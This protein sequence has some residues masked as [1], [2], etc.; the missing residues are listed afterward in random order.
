MNLEKK[1]LR[2]NEVVLTRGFFSEEDT[3]IVRQEY[4]NLDKQLQNSLR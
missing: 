2:N 1:T 3:S 4:D